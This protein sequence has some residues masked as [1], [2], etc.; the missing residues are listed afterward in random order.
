M[1]SL[2]L[3]FTIETKRNNEKN[4]KINMSK[5]RLRIKSINQKYFRDKKNNKIK[6]KTKVIFF[7]IIYNRKLKINTF[8][9]STNNQP[10][11]HLSFPGWK[12]NNQKKK[13]EI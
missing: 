6:I 3:D 5:F 2:L 4:G 8:P 1:M 7:V 13:N 9:K 11:I 10:Y 12:K